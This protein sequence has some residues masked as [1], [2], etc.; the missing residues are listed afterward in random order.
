MPHVDTIKKN[1]H[2]RK[3]KGEIEALCASGTPDSEIS[4]ILNV[5]ASYVSSTVTNYWKRKMNS[6]K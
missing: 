6:K 2:N 1:K 5:S 4:K 3:F